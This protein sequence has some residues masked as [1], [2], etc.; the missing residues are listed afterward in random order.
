M[1]VHKKQ[2]NSPTLFCFTS[3]HHYD[4]FSQVFYAT[5]EITRKILPSAVQIMFFSFF[6]A[7][8]IFL[9]CW[10]CDKFQLV[11]LIKTMKRTESLS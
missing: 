7:F 10:R 4:F 9:M 8:W 1:L 11:E 5:N 3:W 6:Y 2:F